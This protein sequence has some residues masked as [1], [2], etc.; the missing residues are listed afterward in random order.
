MVET[1]LVHLR[2]AGVS[3]AKI[4]GHGRLSFGVAGVVAAQELREEDA[5]GEGVA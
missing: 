4:G 5:R 2:C 3:R 1:T